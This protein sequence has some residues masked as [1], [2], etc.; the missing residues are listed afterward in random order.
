MF[1]KRKKL[2]VPTNNLDQAI[3]TVV[4][5]WMDCMAGYGQE[6]E[7][8]TAFAGNKLLGHAVSVWKESKWS[9]DEIHKSLQSWID[10]CNL[11]SGLSVVR[12]FG[13][14]SGLN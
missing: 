12:V 4:Q 2:E 8:I 10:T 5:S 14:G 3:Q 7:I 9:D 6:P 11:R 13:T 1:W